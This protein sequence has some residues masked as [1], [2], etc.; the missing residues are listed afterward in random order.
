MLLAQHDDFVHGQWNFALSFIN[1]SRKNTDE[2]IDTIG[3]LF[4]KVNEQRTKIKCKKLI[5]IDQFGDASRC[6]LTLVGEMQI[7]EIMATGDGDEGMVG[8]IHSHPRYGT[9]LSSIDMH[10][11]YKIQRELD[12]AVSAVYSGMSHVVS[13]FFLFALCF[14]FELH[15]IL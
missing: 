7:A 4:A 1:Y 12:V 6:G 10:N 9:F 8:L 2:G 14:F 15:V 3:V 13:F 11:V 5:L